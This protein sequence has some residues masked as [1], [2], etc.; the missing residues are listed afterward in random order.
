MKSEYHEML[1][2]LLK[3]FSDLDYIHPEDI[4]NID[5]YMDQVTSFMDDELSNTKRTEEDKILTKTMINNYTK[6]HV[7]PSPV[8]K[9]YSRDHM[10]TLII[11]YYLKNFLSISDIQHIL[12]PVTER[13]FNQKEQTE[14]LYSIYCELVSLE[15]DAARDLINDVIRK[16]K[17]AKSTFQD[18]PEED[19]EILHRFTFICTLAFD[20]YIKKMMIEEIIDMDMPEE[21]DKA[22]K[23]EPKAKS[24]KAD[25][26]SNVKTSADKNH[27]KKMDSKA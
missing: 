11:I 2:K 19:R 26:K 9:K 25:P 6:N 14:S 1:T 24:Q 13:Y 3:N 12:E 22:K 15:H 5:L 23:G 7:L 16:G 21:S 8:K 4:P 27:Q 20:V 18:V 17:L 10:L